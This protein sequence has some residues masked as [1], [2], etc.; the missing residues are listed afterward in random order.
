MAHPAGWLLTLLLLSTSLPGDDPG[1]ISLV[2][3]HP[4]GPGTTEQ[5]EPIMDAFSRS[6]EEVGGLPKGTLRCVY[7]PEAKPGLEYIRSE[8]PS[9]G[10]VSLPF[11]LKHREDLDLRLLLQVVRRDRATQTFHVLAKKGRFADLEALRGKRLLS[12][13]LYDPDFV[14]RVV[15][16]GRE[17]EFL[18]LVETSRLVKETRKVA[19]GEEDAVLV[20]AEAWETLKKMK[21]LGDQ[22]EEIFHSRDLPT[23]P[24]VTIGPP[25]SDPRVPKIEAALKKLAETPRGREILAELMMKRFR[26]PDRKAFGEVERLYSKEPE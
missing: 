24:V 15:L 20:D 2:I 21:G 1:P 25:S 16:G 10:I 8:H 5:A 12:K 17:K 13:H 11:Y 7:H 23:E 19:R 9:L 26:E 22:L 3:C 6:I 14:R 18:H 4:G